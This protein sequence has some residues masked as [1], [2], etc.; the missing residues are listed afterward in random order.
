MYLEK[1]MTKE[2]FIK[3]Y[4]SMTVTDFAKEVGVTRQVIVKMARKY[5]LPYKKN[6]GEIRK[7][8]AI[9][10]SIE[11][12]K[13]LYLTTRTSEL[14]KQFNVSVATL[15]RILKEHGVEMKKPGWGIRERKII[16]EG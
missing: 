3:K 4:N 11:E 7:K 1:I 12:L 14:A 16:V 5:S 10:I 8:K 13:R 15:V 2:E 9:K 6:G